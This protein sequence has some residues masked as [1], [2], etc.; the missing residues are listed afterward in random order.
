MTDCFI[1]GQRKPILAVDFD[2][3]LHKYISGWHGA[4]VVSDDPVDGAIEFLRKA[5]EHFDVAIYSSR[6]KEP[7]GI[8]AMQLWLLKHGWKPETDGELKFPTQKPSAFLTID[9]RC[10]CF[11]GAFP[12]IREL[13]QFKPWNR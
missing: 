1:E 10:W 8:E 2:G 4:H 9:D 5:T 12:N 11:N 3:V 13:L 6:S 7:G